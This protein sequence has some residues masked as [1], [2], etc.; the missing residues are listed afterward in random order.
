MHGFSSTPPT[1]GDRLAWLATEVL[2]R[3]EDA[4][5]IANESRDA[6]LLRV[7]HHL[8]AAIHEIWAAGRRHEEQP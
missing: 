1:I 6:E 7:V 5:K 4:C 8:D 3:R 2:L